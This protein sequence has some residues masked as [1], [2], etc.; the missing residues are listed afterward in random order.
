VPVAA[1][2]LHDSAHFRHIRAHAAICM[3]SGNRSH[4][5][6]HRSQI[7]AHAAHVIE[8]SGEFRSMKFPLV[9]QIS[10]QSSSNRMWFSDACPPP[11]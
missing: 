8:C 2:S 11:C 4:S 3:S 6:A 10:A 5:T 7:S 9:W 1:I